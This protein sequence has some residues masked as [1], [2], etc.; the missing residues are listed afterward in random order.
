MKELI[1]FQE[2]KT[3]MNIENLI[4]VHMGK[5]RCEDYYWDWSTDEKDW[6]RGEKIPE[7]LKQA[8]KFPYVKTN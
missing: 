3:E 1:K 7:N 5:A 6:I 8:Y 4:P 2:K